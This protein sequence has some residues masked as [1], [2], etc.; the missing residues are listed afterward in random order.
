LRG[1]FHLLEDFVNRL[2]VSAAGLLVAV[3]AGC[4]SEPARSGS[5]GSADGGS[6]S[7]TSGSGA[8]AEGGFGPSGSGGGPSS[9]GSAGGSIDLNTDPE[10]CGSPGHSCLGGICLAGHCQPVLVSDVYRADQGPFTDEAW[11]YTFGFT[12]G[13]DF[14]GLIKYPHASLTAT[15][16][17]TDVDGAVNGPPNTLGTNFG[18]AFG[19]QVYFNYGWS[20]SGNMVEGVG[21]VDPNSGAAAVVV[22]ATTGSAQRAIPFT[23]D[24]THLYYA[25]ENGFYRMPIGGGAA[26]M[27]PQPANMVRTMTSDSTHVYLGAGLP[28][29]KLQR[30]TKADNT[31]MTLDDIWSIEHIAVD[32]TTVYTAEGTSFICE[33]GPQTALFATQ[34]NTPGSVTQIAMGKDIGSIAASSDKV[35]WLD[36]CTGVLSVT[37]P[38]GQTEVVWSGPPTNDNFI[39]TAPGVVYWRSSLELWKLAE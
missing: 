22:A 30:Y 9:S 29:A 4:D 21:R 14:Q 12:S 17:P 27:L 25:D 19:G 32:S 28:A 10:N 23:V 5:G 39:A 33:D 38:Q 13:F 37:T 1:F 18:L 26:E 35:Y 15:E 11:V 24:A 3:I 20:S 8:S 7:E 16:V 36:S 2:F 6:G 31:L 34:K